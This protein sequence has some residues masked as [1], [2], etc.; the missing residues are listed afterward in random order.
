MRP[1]V[2]VA[3]LFL[4]GLCGPLAAPATARQSPP[5]VAAEQAVRLTP[6]VPIAG[7]E[8]GPAT[9][10]DFGHA[11]LE[12][13]ER[14][15]QRR[16][17][18]I[19]AGKL[20]GV[21]PD[22]LVK[23]GAAL[24]G[25]LRIPVIPVRYSNVDAPFAHT[26]LQERIFGHAAGDSVSLARYWKEVS[27]GLL[28]IEGGVTPW[29]RLRRPGSHY[30]PKE[31]YGWAS[32]GRAHDLVRDALAGADKLIDFAGFDNDGPDGIPNSGDDDGFIDLVVILYAV[33]CR[34]EWREGSVWP[35]RGALPPLET[36]ARSAAGGR[37]Q[38]AD[39]LIL[40]VQEPGS[41]EPLQLGVLAHETGHALGLPDLYD[42]D[43]GAL[44]AGPWDLMG[45]GGQNAPHSPAHLSAWAKEQLGWV[46]VDWIRPGQDSLRLPPIVHD[47]TVL[48]YDIPGPR[49]E[50]LL[51]ENRQR[52]GTDKYLPGTG[53]LA[54]RIDPDR[55][56]LSGWNG[57]GRYQGVELIR[58]SGSTRRGGTAADPFP[59][60]TRRD[61]LEFESPSP[62]RLSA[63]REEGGGAIVAELAT[64]FR[65]PTLLASAP[66]R[67]AVLPGDTALSRSIPI[68]RL[69]GAAA[70]W[71]PA[72]TAA[73][74]TATR[75]GNL[76][77]LTADPT[78][79]A[80]G[81]YT[82]TI[83]FVLPGVA[84]AGAG[85]GPSGA[86]LATASTPATGTAATTLK[87]AVDATGGSLLVQLEVADPGAPAVLSTEVPWGWGLSVNQ[88]ELFQASFGRDALSLRPRPRL[89]RLRG[90]DQA[91]ETLARLQADAVYAP[92]A[93]PHGSVYLL[94]QAN[95]QNQLFQIQDDG[96][97]TTLASLPGEAPAYGAA[98]L[99]D[100]RLL[101]A[102]WNGTIRQVTPDGRVAPW[103]DL[104][105]HV[106][107]IAVDST[108]ALYAAAENGNIL[109]LD[110]NSGRLT[111]I[112]TGFGHGRLV[113]VAATP[114][115]T[116]FAAERG[117]QGRI[118]RLTPQGTT[119]EVARVAG[120]EFYGL[121]ADHR[122][123]YA[124][125][126]AH[127]QVLRFTLGALDRPSRAGN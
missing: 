40:P 38:V 81:L 123:L 105:R 127:R 124:L 8:T 18:L 89:L 42:Y 36:N 109:H 1:A 103:I 97:T 120:A 91:T 46:Q 3:G 64:D 23:L 68:Q 94:G 10:L 9:P 4:A 54:W 51:F 56:A 57:V 73:W 115:G 65:A 77:Y 41:C 84:G 110:P 14:V 78:G 39:Y 90:R 52:L 7:L 74:A 101:V 49:G 19:R 117:G 114:D 93:G 32:F 108:G 102:D 95:G 35:H 59:G 24:S 53:L 37:L 28:E 62:L 58:A 98:R 13:A 48:R 34:G 125:D 75:M 76:L 79:L 121:A 92:V 20:D 116:I 69:G 5:R 63:I 85:A 61:R 107:Q 55:A 118:L 26:L 106:Y 31:E 33:P 21:A 50:Y 70:N 71:T 17:E 2:L 43:G 86:S 47:R 100:G 60:T 99:A 122:F 15:R 72:S 82:D 96:T 104:G 80:P 66:L 119:T 111:T 67:L 11:W 22:S 12:K 30:L 25:K 29:V 45:T 83:R 88:G 44:G 6:P 27:G 87:S 16:A 112:S 113:T 126:L